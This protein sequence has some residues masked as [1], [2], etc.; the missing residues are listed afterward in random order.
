MA[1]AKKTKAIEQE[2]AQVDPATMMGTSRV[3]PDI[4]FRSGSEF[5]F[6]HNW[7]EVYP[8]LD[9]WYE[10]PI[11]G[12]MPKSGGVPKS[13]DF[14]HS[15]TKTGIELNGGIHRCMGHSTGSGIKKDYEKQNVCNELGINLFVVSTDDM[16]KPEVL[17]M[18][19]RV[20]YKALRGEGNGIQRS[21]M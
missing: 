4:N 16:N 11:P 18:I 1:R 5:S 2:K 20:I 9:L 15:L 21:V 3:D 14:Y 12:T 8:D 7:A 6:A 17:E 10:W 13:I 19:A